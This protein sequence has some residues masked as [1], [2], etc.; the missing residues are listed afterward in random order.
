MKSDYLKAL[1]LLVYVPLLST[2]STY[3]I[4]YDYTPPN[5][6]QG[7]ACIQNSHSLLSQCNN[8][9]YHQYQNCLK[10]SQN[11]AQKALPVLLRDYP[12]QLEVWLNAKE[13]HRRELDWY[14]MRMDLAESRR[15]NYLN[16]CVSKGKKKSK[17]RQSHGYTSLMINLN[18]PDFA[19]SR[20]VK[21]TL[22]SVTARYR[23]ESCSQK[24]GC[25]SN[26]RLS[27]AGCGGVVKSKKVCIKNCN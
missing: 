19:M 2:C 13:Q 9:C 8:R 15:E 11:E 14:E 17:C 16:A 24:C 18:R 6:K 25:Q 26:Y 27:Y 21:P 20:P 5:T 3:K 10:R 1:L 12:N 7:L 23:K 4:A 22:T